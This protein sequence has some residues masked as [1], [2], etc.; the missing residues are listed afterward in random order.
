[1]EE[2]EGG[3]IIK[4]GFGEKNRGVLEDVVG[5]EINCKDWGIADA[6]TY[7][8]VEEVHNLLPRSEE[9]LRDF[10]NLVMNSN[11]VGN[12][13]MKGDEGITKVFYKGPKPGSEGN[14]KWEGKSF[15]VRNKFINLKK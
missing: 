12:E 15:F 10:K 1:M 3:K 13:I 14:P 5:V 8:G 11:W 7:Y 2:K 9:E 4:V 6:N